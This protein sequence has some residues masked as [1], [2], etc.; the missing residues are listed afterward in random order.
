MMNI[1]NLNSSAIPTVTTSYDFTAIY[2]QVKAVQITHAS[3]TASFS[4]QVKG[5]LDGT[6]FAN[7]GSAVTVNNDSATTIVASTEAYPYIRVTVTKTSG[8]LTALS[9]LAAYVPR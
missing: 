3:A 4:I 2:H 5:S 9:L 7:V 8:S 6:N 1:A